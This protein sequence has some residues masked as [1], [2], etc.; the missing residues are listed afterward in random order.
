MTTPTTITTNYFWTYN[1]KDYATKSETYMDGDGSDSFFEDLNNNGV[2]DGEESLID[3]IKSDDLFSW[4]E[5]AYN[6][7]IENNA[8]LKNVLNQLSAI[9]V[10]PFNTI[11]DYITELAKGP[12]DDLVNAQKENKFDLASN[13]KYYYQLSDNDYFLYT[14]L[15]S[16]ANTS[17]YTAGLESNADGYLQ[18]KGHS[19]KNIVE[20]FINNGVTGT[21]ETFVD[22]NAT[23]NRVGLTD[24]QLK[25]S[26][27][28][29]ADLLELYRT[30]STE[31]S[32]LKKYTLNDK[33][34]KEIQDEIDTIRGENVEENLRR[35][36]DK[37]EREFVEVFLAQAQNLV[38][39][40]D[41]LSVSSFFKG[42][43]TN[44]EAGQPQ[45]EMIKALEMQEN[46]RDLLFGNVGNYV[47]GN[48]FYDYFIK[49]NTT[50]NVS[51]DKVLEENFTGNNSLNN[52]SQIITGTGSYTGVQVGQ[53][54]LSPIDLM[55]D[56][57]ITQ[58]LL[59]L[60][61]QYE[62]V[63]T[64]ANYL[65]MALDTAL[66]YSAE[67]DFRQEL[68]R[69]VEELIKEKDEEEGGSSDLF[70]SNYKS[71]TQVKRGSV[72]TNTGLQDSLDM[73]GIYS[74]QGIYGNTEQTDEHT[75]KTDVLVDPYIL[76][77]NG[78]QYILG[79]DINQNGTIDDVA[80]ILG[81][82]DTLDNPF[83]SLISLDTNNDKNI[84]QEELLKAGI[85]LNAVSKDGSLSKSTYDTKL[86]RGIDLN[87]LT[88]T[89][90]TSGT[91]GTFSALLMNGAT[92]NGVQTFDDQS[93]FNKL[94]GKPVDLT[95]Y[96]HEEN[97]VT[98]SD[99]I[100]T[101]TQILTNQIKSIYSALDLEDTSSIESILDSV[102]W[103]KGAVL[104]PAQRIKMI[105][106]VDPLALPYQIEKDFIEKLKTL[107]IA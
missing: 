38:D 12:L 31:M 4:I 42:T 30:L 50:I 17:A 80:E 96:Q 36:I 18:G 104:T 6:I 88:P 23:N 40:G 81:I 9:N 20:R 69:Q 16:N 95:P 99:T 75:K 1:F 34:I 37:A 86:L 82:N 76:N 66:V 70:I 22:E 29:R 7:K 5:D 87:T 28:S 53:E 54:K 71:A 21:A 3:N 11:N 92:V 77:I 106:G 58:E 89:N 84:S 15:G 103:K 47:S 26:S 39:K 57:Y 52:G 27:Y 65:Q 73:S 48:A 14:K 90:N 44:I 51:F 78:T 102:C 46:I 10:T 60:Y 32:N 97:I 72:L 74:F 8:S 107:N 56:L 49:S 93:Y 2:K 91:V 68:A 83:A 61:Q 79:Q 98:E 55:E 13:A 43:S 64:K 45:G 59:A 19:L 101:S 67:Y 25:I 100:S 33:E 85:I 94:F 24:K 41:V 105:E 63:S 62:E 35:Q